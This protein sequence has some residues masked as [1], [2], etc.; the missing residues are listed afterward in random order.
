VFAQIDEEANEALI[1]KSLTPT[2]AHEAL[3]AKLELI[4]CEA[5]DADVAE[6]DWLENDDVVAQNDSLAQDDDKAVGFELAAYEA[7]NAHDELIVLLE[8]NALKALD[9]VP[10]TLAVINGTN[11]VSVPGLN[12]RLL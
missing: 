11:N 1:A 5:Q 8:D 10:N 3:T 6:N 9:D 12:D 7:V 4:D 2:G